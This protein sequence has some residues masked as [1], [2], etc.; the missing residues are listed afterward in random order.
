M[1][2]DDSEDSMM[3]SKR[4]FYRSHATA[5]FAIATSF[6]LSGATST[7]SGLRSFSS[8]DEAFKALVAAVKSDDTRA[9][10]EIF[11]SDAKALV[12]SGDEVADAATRRKFVDEYDRW[13]SGDIID[14]NKVA[15]VIGNDRWPFPIPVVRDGNRWHFDTEAGMDEI[16]SRRLGRNELDVIQVAEAYVDA[17]REYAMTLHDDSKLQEYAQKF[18]S[19][20]GRHNGLFWEAKAGEAQS[21]FGP[22]IG[23]ARGEGY[24]RD[25]QGAPTPYHGYFYRILTQQGPHALGGAYDY[26]VNG[27]MIGGFGLVAFPAQ[28]GA[29]GVMTFIVNQ[30]GVVFQKDLGRDSTKL[31]RALTSFD[32]DRSWSRVDKEDLALLRTP[33]DE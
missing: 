32:P 15:L 28:Y 3:S 27:R 16:L 8:A 30:D 33:S 23:R 24:T 26:V 7:P 13:H 12:Y 19:D 4:R 10:V 21:P 18:F 29:S 31:A 1:T 25:P 22:L 14:K 6:L 5:L 17:Q 9:L 2:R 11:G 20:E